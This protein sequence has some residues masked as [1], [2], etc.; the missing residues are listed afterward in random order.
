MYDFVVNEMNFS[1]ENVIVIGRSI[2]CVPAIH[3]A[4]H[5]KAKMLVCISPFSSLKRILRDKIGFF[6]GMFS[7]RFDNLR[8]VKQVS[9]P[10]LFIHGMKDKMIRLK[11]SVRLFEEVGSVQKLLVTPEDMTHNQFDVQ[12]DV[13]QSIRDFCK[14]Y[15]IP[16]SGVDASWLRGSQQKINFSSLKKY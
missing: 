8:N 7:E 14:L 12:R 10:T 5:R 13:I 16:R 4:G 2:G 1:P 9:S 3:L 6:S 15:Q 11:H